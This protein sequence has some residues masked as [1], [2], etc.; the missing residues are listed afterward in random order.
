MYIV[1]EGNNIFNYM[2]M[3]PKK[4][5]CILNCRHLLVHLTVRVKHQ[6]YQ[7]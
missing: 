5:M 2:Y 3:L 7:N 4:I 6:G 1:V